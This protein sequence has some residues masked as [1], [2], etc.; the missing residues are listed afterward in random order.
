MNSSDKV[1]IG[2]IAGLSGPT[3]NFSCKV[4]Q[5]DFKTD[6]H[7]G[8]SSEMERLES[9]LGAWFSNALCSHSTYSSPWFDACPH[10][11]V[12]TRN[13]ELLELC[14]GDPLDLVENCMWTVK[15]HTK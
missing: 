11:L 2:Y 5:E 15:E 14:S 8:N 6:I 10:E 9:H 13:E 1:C 3:M 4:N 7:A 12:H